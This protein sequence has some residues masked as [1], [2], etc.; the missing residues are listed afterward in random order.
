[1]ASLLPFL[2]IT[3]DQIINIVIFVVVLVVVW[4]ILKAILRFTMK[5]FAFGCGA[6]VVF[7]IVLFLMRILQ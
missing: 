3:T 2:Q 7:G 1:M 4:T 6:L 5:M